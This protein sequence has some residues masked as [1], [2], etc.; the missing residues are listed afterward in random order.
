MRHLWNSGYVNQIWTNKGYICAYLNIATRVPMKLKNDCVGADHYLSS[1]ITTDWDYRWWLSFL[2]DH[3]TAAI[4]LV[5]FLILYWSP[6]CCVTAW[7]PPPGRSDGRVSRLWT[8]CRFRVVIKRTL[9]QGGRLGFWRSN[10]EVYGLQDGF[11][12]REDILLLESIFMVRVL[13]ETKCSGKHNIHLHP[14]DQQKI[15]CSLLLL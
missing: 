13:R 4:W 15:N 6:S 7:L 2:C 14:H 8:W 9:L 5:N 3:W 1:L 11:S 10:V 12:D